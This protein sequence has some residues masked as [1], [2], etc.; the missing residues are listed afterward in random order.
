MCFFPEAKIPEKFKWHSDKFDG[1]GDLRAHLRAYIGQMRVQGFT[2]QQMGQAFQLT[3]SGP[4]L[5]WLMSLE[6]SQTRTW[7]DIMKAFKK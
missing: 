3:L 7:E 5:R 1:T 6:T 4:A 2:D